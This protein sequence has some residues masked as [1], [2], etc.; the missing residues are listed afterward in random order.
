MFTNINKHLANI[1]LSKLIQIGIT[2][3]G[4]ASLKFKLVL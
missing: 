1:F 3:I 2:E 4:N